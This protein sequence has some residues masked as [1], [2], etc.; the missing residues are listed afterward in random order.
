M[1]ANIFNIS[2]MKGDE[3]KDKVN[4]S[5]TKLDYVDSVDVSLEKSEMIIRSDHDFSV[6]EVQE[7]F[8]DHDYPYQVHD[9]TFNE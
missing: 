4:S 8:N 1:A 6:Q 2:G 9:T 3:C 7:I 5:L